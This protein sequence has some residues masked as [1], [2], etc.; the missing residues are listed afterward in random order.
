[1]L[2]EFKGVVI[3]LS[4]ITLIHSMSLISIGK[5][6]LGLPIARVKWSPDGSHL[7]VATGHSTTR[8]VLAII[9]SSG[10]LI[11]MINY[12]HAFSEVSWSPKGDW[13]A[14]GTAVDTWLLP[15]D[16]GNK[17]YIIR[18]GAVMAC[19]DV[20]G[21]IRGGDEVPTLH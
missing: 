17:L 18:D 13:L 16:Y 21:E 5:L 11:F 15:S 10:K 7:A 6:S 19:A 8:G 14:V 4:T 1:M 2:R 3:L 12:P 9:M 20:K